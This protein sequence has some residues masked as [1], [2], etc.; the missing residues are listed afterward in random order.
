MPAHN[1]ILTLGMLAIVAAPPSAWQPLWN[2]SSISSSPPHVPA[3]LPLSLIRALLLWRLVS[4]PHAAPAS[5]HGF[6]GC[7]WCDALTWGVEHRVPVA[8]SV[9]AAAAQLS[10][11]ISELSD[12][13]GTASSFPRVNLW[14]FRNNDKKNTVK[15]HFK[16]L[17]LKGE[18]AVKT[19]RTSALCRPQM[20]SS[21]SLK[22]E[23]RLLPF[24][25][26][27]VN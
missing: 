25:V 26:F 19:S 15:C 9:G 7:V 20:K 8:G 18:I 16:I 12:S 1:C 10:S 24:F 4:R 11:G 3:S 5:I 23:L 13:G 17:R 14:L 6:C 21:N 22:K 2:T 27:V